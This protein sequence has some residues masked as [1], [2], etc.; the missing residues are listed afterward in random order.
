MMKQWPHENEQKQSKPILGERLTRNV[1]LCALLLLT[2]VSV[3]GQLTGEQTVLAALQQNIGRDWDESIGKLTFVSAL[4]PETALVFSQSARGT[5]LVAPCFSALKTPFSAQ[6][7]YLA[8]DN[9]NCA[10]YPCAGGTVMSLAHGNNEERILR[11]RH[12][13]GLETLYYNLARTHVTEGDLVDTNTVLGTTLLG[14]DLILEARV[15]GVTVDPAQY[16]TA[17]ERVAR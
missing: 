12:A 5:T 2:V 11:L 15:D 3:R 14:E 10:V 16:M 6:T 7:P 4:F 17:T 13:D 9:E 8:Y 1:A